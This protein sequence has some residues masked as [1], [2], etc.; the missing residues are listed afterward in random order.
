MPQ[1]RYRIIYEAYN[2]LTQRRHVHLGHAHGQS[3]WSALRHWWESERQWG[4]PGIKVLGVHLNHRGCPQ[5]NYGTHW[6]YACSAQPQHGDTD[7]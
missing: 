4:N 1:H 2:H 5:V 6:A 7:E 3:R